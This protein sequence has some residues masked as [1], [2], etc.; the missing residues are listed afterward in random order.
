MS[1]IVIRGDA[2]HRI[3]AWRT[4]DPGERAKA[5]RVARPPVQVDGQ[6]ALFDDGEAS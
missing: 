2:R 4:T 5:M 6:A 1:A 3:A